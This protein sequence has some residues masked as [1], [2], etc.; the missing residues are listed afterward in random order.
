MKQTDDQPKR[1]VLSWILEI[2]I[3]YTV[4]AQ[5]FEYKCEM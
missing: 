3:S 1:I 2:N 5:K 4:A